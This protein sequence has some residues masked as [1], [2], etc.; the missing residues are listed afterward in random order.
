MPEFTL[1][2]SALSFLPLRALA[3][4][5]YCSFSS[6]LLSGLTGCTAVGRYYPDSSQGV[7][8]RLNSYSLLITDKVIIC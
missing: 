8:L 6:F 4:Q 1:V 2:A 7:L 3:A 5:S